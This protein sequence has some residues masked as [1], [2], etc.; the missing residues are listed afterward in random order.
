VTQATPATDADNPRVHYHYEVAGFPYA[1]T[2]ITDESS[3]RYATFQYDYSGHAV[4][5]QHAG[6]VE[7]YTFS[8][9]SPGY[10][11]S[12]TDP[13]GTTRTYSFQ[14][15]LSYNNDSG[16]T[17]PASSGTGTVTQ[18]ETYDANGNPASVT[19]R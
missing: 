2:G 19:P 14:Q 4:N 13:L 11:A 6:G 12:V 10:N 3:A 7:S 5:T 8:Y 15:G 1:L 18:S 9:P 17:Q 16:Q